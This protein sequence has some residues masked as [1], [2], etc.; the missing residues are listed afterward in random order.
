MLQGMKKDVSE[1]HKR[2]IH[3]SSNIPAHLPKQQQHNGG[4]GQNKLAF[5]LDFTTSYLQ[6]KR[7][8]MHI[9]FIQLY[10]NLSFIMRSYFGYSNNNYWTYARHYAY[11]FRWYNMII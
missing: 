11:V 6:I 3:A 4:G 1:L 2:I 7:H 10:H 5:I 8:S 9:W